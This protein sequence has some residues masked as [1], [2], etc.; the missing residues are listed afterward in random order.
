MNQLVPFQFEAFP[1]RVVVV[2]DHPLFSARD[3]ALALGYARPADAYQDHCKLLKKLS[4]GDLT[5]LNWANPNP[6]GEYVM[7]ESDVYRLIVKSAKPEAE[8][9]E[10]WVFEEVLPSIRK[11]GGYTTQPSK[12]AVLSR[13]IKSAFSS[14]L[15]IAKLCGFSGNMALLS[16]DNGTRTLTG[17]SALALIGATH[18]TA[19]ERGRTYTPTQLCQ[20]MEPKMS[21]IKTNLLLEASG[22]QKKDM[23]EWMPTD[24]GGEFC[25]WLDTGKKHTNG[26]PVKQLKWF[27]T[28]LNYLMTE[29]QVA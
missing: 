2:D 12:P 23:G 22:L 28:V 8:R 20:M 6:Q 5:K 25:E 24:K 15:A 18:L 27:D 1:I 4:F 7:P 14:C 3:V 26:A 17:V 21:A 29:K 10:R 11:T 19:D 9:F 13:Q 16:A